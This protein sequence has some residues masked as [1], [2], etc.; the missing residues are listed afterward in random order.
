[1][2]LHRCSID[3]YVSFGK[4]PYFYRALPQKEPYFYRALSLSLMVYGLP[5]VMSLMWGGTDLFGLAQMPIY[6]HTHKH[7]PVMSKGPIE[8]GLFFKRDIQ[9]PI[10]IGLFSKRDIHICGVDPSHVWNG[11]ATTHMGRHRCSTDLYRNRAL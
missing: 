8:I 3:L 11:V 4:E 5:L 6:I 10:E 9:I 1:M 7:T 2:G